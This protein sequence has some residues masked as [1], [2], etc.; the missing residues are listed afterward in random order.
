MSSKDG[1]AVRHGGR[2][3]PSRN[4][5]GPPSKDRNWRRTLAAIAIS[6]L[7]VGGMSA[8]AAAPA[9]AEEAAG[10]V[11]AVT[12][13][14][15]APG[16][17][18]AEAAK[19]KK[20]PA[21]E[22]EVQPAAE[23]PAPA[24]EPAE[25]PTEEVAEAP[26]DEVVEAAAAVAPTEDAAA[27]DVTPLLVPPP[28]DEVVPKVEICH[29]TSSYKHPYEINE[30]AADGDVS[31]HADHTGPIFY[32]EIPKHTAWGDIIPPFTYKDPDGVHFFA[33]LN[34]DAVG[35]EIFANDSEILT[36][37]P[38]LFVFPEGCRFYLDFG[39]LE[40]EVG[41]VQENVDYRVIVLDS[42]GNPA[43]D[44]F[45]SE[46]TGTVS[47]FWALPPG[48]YT[49]TL[50][51]SIIEGEWE[52]LDEQAF[53]ISA[54]PDLDVTV[55]TDNCSTGND[56]HAIVIFTGLIEGEVYDFS[57]DGPDAYRIFGGFIADAPS[58]E[59][60]LGSAPPG[61]FTASIEFVPGP[62]AE[63]VPSE[64]ATTTFT[65]VPCPPPAKPVKPAGLA[66]TGTERTP[67][68]SAALLLFGLGGAMLPA[69]SRRRR[70]S[71]RT[72]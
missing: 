16:A 48:D 41:P 11:E 27:S 10:A 19:D 18:V 17:D 69:T 31:G 21:P 8:L 3:H 15:E 20:A 53:S 59:V 49:I 42:E 72:E 2:G 1:V 29:A 7:A 52:L 13:G 63:L 65:V 71:S 57:V 51:Q 5:E 46:E 64:V 33:G 44:G 70:G 38:D 54:C 14:T 22:A 56:G 9:A 66:V 55:T 24:P 12:D 30:P 36:P 39:T 47:L 61:D 32:P 50:E 37:E 6:A 4:S 58:S 25:A 45:I 35:Q 67:F 28:P 26:T 60:E 23:A 40:A 68:L 43:A 34:W 62:G